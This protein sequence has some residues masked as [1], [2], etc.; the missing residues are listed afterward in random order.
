MQR[1]DRI[2]VLSPFQL[3]RRLPPTAF[4]SAQDGTER[5]L[6]LNLVRY[7]LDPT[8]VFYYGR[9]RRRG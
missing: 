9:G 7:F 8:H 1:A 3:K 2:A 5:S 6:L 4:V